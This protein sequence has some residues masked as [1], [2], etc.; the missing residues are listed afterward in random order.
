MKGS[1]GIFV[2]AVDG[3]TVAAK[4][5]EAGFPSEADIVAAVRTKVS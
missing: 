2:V 4:S 5:R 3:E 1:G